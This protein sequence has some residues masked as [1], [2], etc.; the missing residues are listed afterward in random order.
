MGRFIYKKCTDIII[1]WTVGE[2]EKK[3]I[4]NYKLT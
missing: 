2:T 1:F 4:K 3:I